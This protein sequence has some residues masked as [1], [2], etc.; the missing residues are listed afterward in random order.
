MLPTIVQEVNRVVVDLHSLRVSADAAVTAG[1]VHGAPINRDP[2]PFVNRAAEGF[3]LFAILLAPCD[4]IT[5]PLGYQLMGTGKTALGLNA[6]SIL[7]RPREAPGE[8]EDHVVERLR[9]SIVLSALGPLVRD[10]II[11][12]ARAR[13]EDETLVARALRE[14]LIHRGGDPGRVDATKSA[15]TVYV[16]LTREDPSGF[17]S[18]GAYVA[19][20]IALAVEM[21][22]TSTNLSRTCREVSGRLEQTVLLVLDEIGELAEKDYAHFIGTAI[23]GP[24]HLT[25]AMR[26]L[27]SVVNRIAGCGWLI[28]CAGRTDWLAMSA[29]VG[30]ASP[31]NA[32]A[33]LIA[34][35]H[36][37]DVLCLMTSDAACRGSDDPE[38]R[39][40]LAEAIAQR[41]GGLARLV[42]TA[43]NEL[44]NEP[45]RVTSEADALLARVEWAL[46]RRPGY[47]FPTASLNTHGGRDPALLSAVGR[48]VIF[49][50]RFRETDE[51][52][53][54]TGSVLVTSALTALGFN[55]APVTDAAAGADPAAAALLVPV[56]GDWHVRALPS[57]LLGAE[58]GFALE[59]LHALRCAGKG[60][61]SGTYF[62]QLC[63]FQMLQLTSAA[64]Q[65]GK[66]VALG[67]ALPHLAHTPAAT[68][69]VGRLRPR[70]LPAV[71]S[72][73]RRLT[74]AQK[75]SPACID[76]LLTIHP[77]DRRWLLYEA[78][79]V[80]ELGIPR[81]G[82]SGSQDWFVRAEGAVLGVSN[83]MTGGLKLSAVTDELTKMP[84]L[85]EADDPY[86][87][88]NYAPV[89]APKLREAV[90]P[91]AALVL[92]GAVT[93]A[94]T[95]PHAE[96]TLPSVAPMASVS[97]PRGVTIVVVS[98]THPDGLQRLLTP[99]A[100][101][102]V[103]AI[104][105][106]LRME[107]SYLSRIARTHRP[108]SL[109]DSEVH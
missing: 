61:Q 43:L 95:P 24:E 22:V 62:E 107:Y 67:N 96:A 31:L 83:K 59:L 109:S 77:D 44:R 79:N 29:I 84:V 39:R 88:V 78:L 70:V 21:P 49:G 98:P 101:A 5:V 58:G 99:P 9:R 16:D 76:S 80:D 35:L 63:L 104:A 60:V 72:Q 50:E 54:A 8:E 42:I 20:A 97:V 11:Q 33:I 37:R 86:I 12:R 6:V 51:L 18:L 41:S 32:V 14:Y 65:G 27:R 36:W 57:S 92:N 106:G 73:S 34:P 56:A 38:V 53:L 105:G 45:V 82:T 47:L 23:T 55:F 3:D 13:A 85:L 48:M 4:K 19:H 26:C 66:R 40:Y 89:L 75:T 64:A 7:R 90:G 108:S 68:A 2:L 71:N 87:L 93:E 25:Q 1:H 74:A 103:C 94:A 81:M 69:T 52:N 10:A 102:E 15:A 100:C 30:P 91:K 17:D 28:Y 46:L